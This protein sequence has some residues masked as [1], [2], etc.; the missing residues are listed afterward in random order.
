MTANV[1]A[2]SADFLGLEDVF[3]VR[4]SCSSLRWS[5]VVGSGRHATNM[6]NANDRATTD[7]HENTMTMRC[8]V[9]NVLSRAPGRSG[10]GGGGD[11]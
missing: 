6:K 10:S 2:S 1:L 11:G 5:A 9:Q 4:L 7:A 3:R 8:A